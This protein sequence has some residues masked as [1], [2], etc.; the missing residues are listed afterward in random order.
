[1]DKPDPV[2]MNFE[3]LYEHPRVRDW[4]DRN[5]EYRHEMFKKMTKLLQS[6]RS[7]E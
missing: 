2:I 4:F 1:M 5:P 6:K 7:N 3:S